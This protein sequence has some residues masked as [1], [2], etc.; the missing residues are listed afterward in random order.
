MDSEEEFR[1]TFSVLRGMRQFPWYTDIS[2]TESSG[3]A[4]LPNCPSWPGLEVPWNERVRERRHLGNHPNLARRNRKS[5]R[6]PTGQPGLFTA[7][8]Q[9]EQAEAENFGETTL[10][11]NNNDGDIA[12]PGQASLALP[13]DGGRLG[14]TPVGGDFNLGAS[15]AAG[16]AAIGR[17]VRM[18]A[19]SPGPAADRCNPRGLRATRAPWCYTSD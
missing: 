8:P 4:N 2:R 13:G 7:V 11:D 14:S 10:S 18:A 3:C 15:P 6:F 17:A 1:Q 12:P 16:R 5:E 19:G 9:T